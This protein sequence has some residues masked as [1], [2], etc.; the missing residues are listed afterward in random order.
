MSRT[1]EPKISDAEARLPRLK[2]KS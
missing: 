1:L 2:A